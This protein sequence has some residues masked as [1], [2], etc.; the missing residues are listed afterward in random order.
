MTAMINKKLGTATAGLAIVLGAVACNSDKLTSL[1]INPNAPADVPVTTLFTS[2]VQAAAAQWYGWT[3]YR[4]GEILTQQLAEVQYPDEDRYTRIGGGSTTFYFDAPFVAELEDF[5]QVIDR[6]TTASQPGIYGPAL[7]MKT[8]DYGI[9]TDTWGDVPYSEALAGTPTSPPSTLKPKYDAQKDIYT[10]FFRILTK[11]STD[12]EAAKTAANPGDLGTADLL[13][14][15]NLTKWQ[16]FANSLHARYAMRLVNVDPVT[17][18]AELRKAFTAPGGVFQSNADNAELKWPG[19]GI[20][21][22]P[23]AVNFSS[24]DDHRISRVLMELLNTTVDPRRPIYAM[25]AASDGA[26]RGAPNGITHAKGAAFL[27]TASRPGAVFYP[28]T[29]AYGY[30]GG[31]GNSFPSFLMTYAEVAFIQAEAAQRGIGGLT[32]TAA[33]YYNAGIQASMAQWGVSSTDAA[34]YLVRPGVVYAPATGF[35]QIAQQKWVALYTDGLQAW[36]EWR[37]TCVPRTVQPGEDAS[38]NIVPRRLQ[39]SDTEYSVN[40]ANL[41][42][43]ATR[44]GGDEFQGRMYWDSNPTAAPTYFVGCGVRGVAPLPAP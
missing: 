26:F 35:A 44:M 25:P 11:V 18:D 8:W 17:A 29:T 28:G 6:G 23:W 13:Y 37:R 5:Q 39:Y 14:S 42:I 34:A 20:Y 16:R 36:A 21:N 38:E 2:G 24:R 27:L 10:D 31:T 33:S 19:D 32:G 1:N 4:F 22:N 40:A 12:L 3:D 30:Y 7:V 15:G 43:A 9:I 41:D